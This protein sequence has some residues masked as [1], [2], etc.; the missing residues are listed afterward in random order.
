M[1]NVK[2]FLKAFNKVGLSDDWQRICPK[3]FKELTDEIA[4]YLD[5]INLI[6]P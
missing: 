1:R 2:K 6:T 4:A 3:L 5:A